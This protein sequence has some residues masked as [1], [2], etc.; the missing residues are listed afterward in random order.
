MMRFVSSPRAKTR[1]LPGNRARHPKQSNGHAIQ[2]PETGHGMDATRVGHVNRA[3]RCV[4]DS[5]RSTVIVAANAPGTT[6]NDPLSPHGRFSRMVNAAKRTH[7]TP[8]VAD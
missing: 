1:R 7:L 2:P 3:L 5:P 4:I 8:H 6:F